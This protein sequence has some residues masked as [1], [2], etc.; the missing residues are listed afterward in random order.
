[1]LDSNM[2][3]EVYLIANHDSRWQ[4]KAAAG[5]VKLGH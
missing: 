1:M 2:I 4:A 3:T 5:V